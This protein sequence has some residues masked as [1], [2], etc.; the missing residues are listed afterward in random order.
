MIN[1]NSIRAVLF[2]FDG[3]L[4]LPGAL[5]FPS[6]R[7]A[8]G[9]PP[10]APILEFISMQDP[11]ARQAMME[12]LDFLETEAAARSTPNE[13]ALELIRWLRSRR[14]AL[15]ILTR[16][17]RLSVLRALK[18]FDG[19]DAGAF[20]LIITRDDP[21]RP[22]P[23]G[24]GVLMAARMLKLDPG[25][26]L[27][28]GDFVYDCMAAREAGAPAVLLDPLDDARLQSVDCDYRIR[29]LI[30]LKSLLG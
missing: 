11:P 29:R 13:G 18:N 19:L 7:A 24:D 2:D 17:S 8:L 25:R 4:T 27:V 12:R 21:L 15:G 23:S 14:M 30:E 1:P 16:N 9:C 10:G 5:D 22:K 6:I 28:V 26:M 20:D 3:T